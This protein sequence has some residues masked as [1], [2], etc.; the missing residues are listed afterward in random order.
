M[1]V[2]RKS[3]PIARK[4]YNCD[5]WHWYDNAGIYDDLT[6]E[7]KAT[8][9]NCAGIIKKGERY[10]YVVQ[11]Y[12]GEFNIFRANIAIDAICRK[13]NLYEE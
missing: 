9:D 7:E 8:V 1:D 2:I 6:E 13:Y 3:Q 10:I 5:A 12:W 4:D 11:K